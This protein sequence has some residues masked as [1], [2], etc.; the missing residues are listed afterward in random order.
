MEAEKTALIVAIEEA[1]TMEEEEVI[2][3]RV[4]KIVRKGSETTGH[5]MIRLTTLGKTM[6]RHGDER[7]V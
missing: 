4:A 3:S 7:K 5:V 2:I 1:A 6:G